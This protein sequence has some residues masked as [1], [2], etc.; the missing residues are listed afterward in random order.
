MKLR[1]V[2]IGLS[3]T[4]SGVAMAILVALPA[5]RRKLASTMAGGLSLPERRLDPVSWIQVLPDNRIRLLVPKAEMGQGT[6]TGLAQI[7]AEELEVPLDQVEVVHAST[8]QA[9]N[10]YRGTVGSMAI[11]SLYDPLRQAAAT[12]REMLRAE[13]SLRLGVSPEQLVACNGRFEI[14][15]SPER[16]IAYSALVD[17]KTRWQAP[18]KPVAL[19]R[20]ERFGVIGQALP[21]VDGRAKVSGEAIFGQDVRVEGTLYGA[22]V[23]PPTIGAVMLSARPG[24][25]PSMPGV[26]KVV[27][28]DG[29][30]GVVARTSNQ[31]RAARDALDVTWSTG[32]LWQQHELEALVT[33][34]GSHGVTIQREG[35]ARSVLAT[36]TTLHA[37]YRT[38]L[39]AHASMETQA[40]LAVVGERGVTIWT[41]TQWETIA[42]RQVARALGINVNQ[43]EVIPTFLGGGFGRKTNNHISWAAAEAARL[44]RAAG[45][46]VHVGWDPSEE[47][48]N[49]YVR[50]MTPHKLSARVS[51][52]RIE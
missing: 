33:V 15:G 37:E 11:H 39:V 27:I 35:N 46:P 44:S 24:K 6:H 51:D 38:G 8:R 9:E 52:G 36:G 21:R 40:A 7:A 10:K 50:P 30:A 17:E 47:F 26:V 31:A 23:R 2:V 28:E 32:R 41:S 18:K 25:A 1:H 45:A 5:L 49:G 19:K 43:V 14:I 34:G 22:V 13:A 48:R 29:F 42:A 20:P 12:M 4:G 3:V 16:G